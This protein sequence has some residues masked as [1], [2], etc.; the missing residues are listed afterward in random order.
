MAVVIQSS[1][2]PA[3]LNLSMW[4]R[5]RAQEYRC[6]RC[7]RLL[8]ML[9]MAPGAY[10]DIKCGR[11]GV[12]NVTDI[13]LNSTSAPIMVALL[14]GL[15]GDTPAPVVEAAGRLALRLQDYNST[16]G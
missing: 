7:G 4:Q 12:H 16:G 3:R 5:R 6:H 2:E 14:D 15:N 8:G 10:V 11:C 9:I 1:P 13:D